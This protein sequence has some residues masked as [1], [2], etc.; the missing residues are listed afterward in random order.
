M[1]TLDYCRPVAR[2]VTRCG[3]TPLSNKRSTILPKRSTILFEKATNLS[4]KS[5]ILFEKTTSLLKSP[6][7]C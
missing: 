6:L 1:Y 2:G 3:R 4:K 7:F 5:T